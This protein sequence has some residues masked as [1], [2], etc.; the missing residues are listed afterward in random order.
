MNCE[1]KQWQPWG[2]CSKSCDGGSQ[3]RIRTVL[4]NPAHGGIPCYTRDK[5]ETRDCNACPCRGTASFFQIELF[6][7][8]FN[9]NRKRFV[10]SLHISF[11]QSVA[12][13]SSSGMMRRTKNFLTTS[14]KSSALMRLRIRPSTVELTTNRRMGKEL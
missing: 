6:R 10:N 11:F 3:Q 2:Q 12:R 8:T 7:H 9:N 1:W 4:K 14:P 5:E 13:A